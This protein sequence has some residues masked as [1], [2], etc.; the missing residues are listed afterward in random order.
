MRVKLTA[1][2]RVRIVIRAAKGLAA[3]D[4]PAAKVVFDLGQVPGA[5][6]PPVPDPVVAPPAPEPVPQV[7]VP[8][9]PPPLIL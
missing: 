3:A 1:G 6:T 9:P 8:D 7:V 2:D 4:L 5:A